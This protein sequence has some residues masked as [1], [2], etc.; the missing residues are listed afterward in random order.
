[1]ADQRPPVSF[2]AAL[3][4]VLASFLDVAQAMIRFRKELIDGGLP[5]HIADEMAKQMGDKIVHM[6]FSAAPGQAGFQQRDG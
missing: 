1:M 2:T 6:I 5:E 4:Q 3:D